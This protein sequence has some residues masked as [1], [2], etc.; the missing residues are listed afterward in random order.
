MDLVCEACNI[1]LGCQ[2]WRHVI[3]AS[4]SSYEEPK[5]QIACT[6]RHVKYALTI[7]CSYAWLALATCNM[8]WLHE[9]SPSRTESGSF[10]TYFCGGYVDLLDSTWHQN[11]LTC[12]VLKLGFHLAL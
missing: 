7:T 3:C 1:R 8:R 6:I 5:H 2:V 9:Q 12:K 4:V 11:H 10:V